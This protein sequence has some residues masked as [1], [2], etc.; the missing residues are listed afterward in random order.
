MGYMKSGL[1]SKD[2]MET[3]FAEAIDAETDAAKKK[4]LRANLQ[5]LGNVKCLSDEGG[6]DVGQSGLLTWLLAK[7]TDFVSKGTYV[8]TTLITAATVGAASSAA[9]RAKLVRPTSFAQF[10][11]AVNYFIMYYIALGMGNAIILMQFFQFALHDTMTVRGR[12]WRVAFE[13][14]NILFRRVEDAV[15]GTANLMTV[16]TE[17][18][19][20]GVIEEAQKSAEFFW[21]AFFRGG[22]GKRAPGGGH[23]GNK[24]DEQGS[25]I[26][27]NGK[28]SKD[29]KCKPCGAYNNKKQGSDPACSMDHTDFHLR[30]CGTCKFQHKCNHWVSD[31]GKKGQCLGDHPRFECDNPNKC[32]DAVK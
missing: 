19:I 9:H 4:D 29:D 25:T 15:P 26:K 17:Q 1:V 2:Q 21:P 31:K 20:L 7:V 24:T 16:A 8:T 12:D 11:E 3:A 18:F 27:W 5:M 30:A 23:D 22:A 32:N 13:L 28:F 10:M 6:S 14:V